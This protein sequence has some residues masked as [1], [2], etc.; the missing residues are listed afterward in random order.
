M[1]PLKIL[2][3]TVPLYSVFEHRKKNWFALNNRIY[4]AN[5][6]TIDVSWSN[7]FTNIILPLTVSNF[8]D[9]LRL[10][11]PESFC[12]I[13]RS[14]KESWPEYEIGIW[15]DHQSRFRLDIGDCHL[16]VGISM[17]NVRIDKKMHESLRNR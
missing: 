16:M 10:K 14:C 4:L 3:H 15:Q 2:Q 12:H 7:F 11:I 5:F 1:F 13:D 17:L 8:E 9:G 6:I